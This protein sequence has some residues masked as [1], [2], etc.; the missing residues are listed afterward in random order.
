MKRICIQRPF[1]FHFVRDRKKG[2]IDIEKVHSIVVHRL[3]MLVIFAVIYVCKKY[4]MN[5]LS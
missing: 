4:G 2:R 1:H 3:D 5:F